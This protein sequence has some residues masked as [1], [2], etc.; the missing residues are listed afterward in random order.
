MNRLLNIVIKIMVGYLFVNG[1]SYFLSSFHG[2]IKLH[3][4]FEILSYVIPFLFFILFFCSI[5]FNSNKISNIIIDKYEI[6]VVINYKEIL[7]IVIITIS[8][9]YIISNIG[10]I[11]LQLLNLI[12]QQLEKNNDDVIYSNPY[13]SIFTIIHSFVE[14][15]ISILLLIFRKKLINN[16]E[17]T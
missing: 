11:I 3:N 7:S 17:K 12:K 10:I 16:F 4:G 8:L 15:I 13:Y 9:Y 5:W 1:I 6:S 14:I 2:V